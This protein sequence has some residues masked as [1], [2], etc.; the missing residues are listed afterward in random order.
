MSELDDLER[1]EREL[2]ERLAELRRKKAEQ[3][4][5]EHKRIQ[6]ENDWD[7]AIAEDEKRSKAVTLTVLELINDRIHFKVDWRED[8]VNLLRSMPDRQYNHINVTNSIGA[9]HWVE[10]TDKLQTLPNVTINYNEKQDEV[11]AWKPKANYHVSMDQRAF[12]VAL[13]PKCKVNYTI[14]AIP[15]TVYNHSKR[16]YRYPLTEGWRIADALKEEEGVEWDED[17]HAFVLNQIDRRLSLDEIAKKESSELEITLN[18][19]RLKPFQ[20]VTVEY[21]E[22]AGGK[23][24]VAHEMGLGKTPC[25]IAA[26]ERMAERGECEK[27]LIV[28]PASLKPNWKREIK[29]FTGFR[30]Y[31][32]FGS[33]PNPYDMAQ[34]IAGKHRYY[35][36][37]YDILSEK[38]VIPR[39]VEEVNGER[40]E[41]PQQERFLWVEC[42]N[43]GS[44]GCVV[45]DEAHYAKNVDALRSRAVRMLQSPRK[46]LLSGTP[47]MNRPSE[48]WPLIKM[49]DEESAGSFENFVKQY[50][51]DGKMA[52]N[53]EELRE[54]MKPLMIRRIKKDVLKDLPPINRIEREYELSSPA[55]RAYQ[56]VLDGFWVELN[57]WN[58]DMSNTKAITSFLAQLLKMKQICSFDK[59]EYIVDLA[60][61]AYEQATNG[62]RKVLIFTQ[63]VNAPEMVKQLCDK[64]NTTSRALG[65]PDEALMFTGE[66]RVEE[67]QAI[68]DRFQNDPDV[69][70]LVCST[71]AASE[72]LNITAAGSVIFADLMWTPA[73]H[74]Q[75]EGRAY[76]R[77][78]DLH[79][80]NSYYVISEDTIEE[81][82]MELLAL[83]QSV[84]DNVIEGAE[85]SRDTSI[86]MELIKRLKERR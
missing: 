55:R 81:D 70:F 20:E 27:F 2:A 71:K 41:T 79:S 64:L 82:V 58:G 14:R 19:H 21:I 62:H 49:L 38:T 22:A 11:S 77:L 36:I 34:V 5:A 16:E 4:E 15:G 1:E 7:A 57:E 23:A 13:G 65:G 54:I 31:E 78:S 42:L 48:L 76:G 47:L 44:F 80:I 35:I 68:V 18:G 33:T 67:R 30:A 51:I 75:A 12:T 52:R 83:K 46:L 63:F 9:E 8:V 69:H 66:D 53:V 37:N 17:A 29:K 43:M 56:K 60:N 26:M 39:K 24:L 84:F 28:V 3:I 10:F 40:I 61:E 72:G 74:A 6:Y 86:A 25:A 50:T 59:I 73:A 32:L 85:A 45:L